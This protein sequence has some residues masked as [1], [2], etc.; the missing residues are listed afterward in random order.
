MVILSNLLNVLWVLLLAG[1]AVV[2]FLRFGPGRALAG[3]G[4]ICMAVA[5]GVSMTLTRMVV[6]DLNTVMAVSSLD[7]V[8]SMVGLGLLIAAILR[9]GP[10][11][12]P[13]TPPTS[14]YAAAYP[15]PYSAQA[16]SYPA[17]P[18]SYPAQPPS[19]PAQQPSWGTPS[20]PTGPPTSP[21]TGPPAW[22][23]PGI[24][25]LRPPDGGPAGGTG[26]APDRL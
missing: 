16:P 21:R 10:G 5:T 8:M 1:A 11:G 2:S 17:Q 3:V 9:R 18:P 26:T 14:P 6:R 20:P 12:S 7:Q 22:D 25:G 13:A 24:P 19:Y 23:L 15:S 4:F